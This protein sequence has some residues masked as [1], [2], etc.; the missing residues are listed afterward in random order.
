MTKR[1]SIMNYTHETTGRND[2]ET[3]TLSLEDVMEGTTKYFELI[4]ITMN[5]IDLIKKE[6]E[7]KKHHRA[8]L[9]VHDELVRAADAV[10]DAISEQ[11]AE[12][13]T[14]SVDRYQRLPFAVIEEDDDEDDLVVVKKTDFDIMIDD[15][16]TLVE[17]VSTVTEMRMEDTRE[18]KRYGGFYLF[19]RNR[20]NVYEDA[21]N[22][23]DEIL[24][25]LEELTELY[26]I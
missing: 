5:L 26:D 17:L 6:D 14:H 7:L 9:H 10:M 18:L 2:P 22:K 19:M 8:Y 13:D 20:L 25:D 4:G 15:I 23:A 12:E 16:I 3:V 11:L 21:C 24:S 1:E